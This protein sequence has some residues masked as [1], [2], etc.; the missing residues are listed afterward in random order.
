MEDSVEESASM[1]VPSSAAVEADPD[2]VAEGGFSGGGI[3]EVRVLAHLVFE[4]KTRGIACFAEISTL[5]AYVGAAE[6]D[7]NLASRDHA[8]AVVDCQKAVR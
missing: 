2:E 3:V 6:I 1:G 5:S 8:V 4:S 7:G